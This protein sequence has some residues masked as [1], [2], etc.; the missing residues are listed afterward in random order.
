MEEI[1]AQTEKIAFD[2]LKAFGFQ[3][4]QIHSLVKQ[5]KEDLLKGLTKLQK[6]L[7]EETNSFDEID[8][9][10]HS[11]KGLSFQLGNHALANT[12][13]EIEASS[14]DEVHLAKLKALI[15]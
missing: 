1:I 5:G 12:F 7:K 4:E 3:D 8:D 15:A 14:K 10:L 6:I 9:I 11:L 2:H 13:E